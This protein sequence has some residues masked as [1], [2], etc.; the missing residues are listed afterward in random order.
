VAEGGTDRLSFPEDFDDQ[1]PLGPHEGNSAYFG[2]DVL[3]GLITGIDDFIQARQPRW[4]AFR[5]V[6]PVLLGSAGWIDDH[7][8]IDKLTELAGASI[9]V[10]KQSRAA[11]NL[12]WLREVNT[13]TPGLPMDAFA[14]LRDLALKVDGEPVV[15]GPYDRIDEIA[16]PT[17]RTIGFRKRHRNEIPLPPLMHAKLALLGHLW[18]HDEDVLGYPADLVFFTSRRLWVSSANFTRGS[19]H[20]L[21][22]GYWTEDEALLRGAERFLTTA[23]RY[24]EGVDPESDVFEP[25]FAPVEW[26]DEA[27]RAALAEIDWEPDEDDP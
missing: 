16:I 11:K 4:R 25:E 14:A 24:S 9:V 26:D 13:R 5:S 6:G 7:E 15:L 18:W 22:F 10:T 17:I 21:E 3:R 19:R 20:S 27:I 8:L 12:K 23:M 1:F 2:R